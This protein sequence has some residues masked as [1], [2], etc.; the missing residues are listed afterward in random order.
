MLRQIE[1]LEN[2][3]ELASERAALAVD[4]FERTR[5]G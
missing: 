5:C 2:I 1:N 3:P 4:L